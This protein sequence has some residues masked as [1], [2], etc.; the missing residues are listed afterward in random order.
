MGR[1]SRLYVSIDGTGDE[2][3][4]VRVGGRSVMVGEG[5]LSF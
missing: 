2:V 5:K 3:T 4:R 1:P